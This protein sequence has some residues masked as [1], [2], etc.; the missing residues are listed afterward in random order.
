MPEVIGKRCANLKVSLLVCSILT[1][2]SKNFKCVFK[3]EEINI[4]NLFSAIIPIYQ[5]LVCYLLKITS[6][7]I[8]KQLKSGK[9]DFWAKNDSQVYYAKNLAIAFIQVSIYPLISP[10]I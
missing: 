1:I 5:W 9:S 3:Y 10:H 6:G 2:L 4:L 7:K 8:E